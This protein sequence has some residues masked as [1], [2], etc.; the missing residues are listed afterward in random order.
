MFPA[1]FS[2]ITIADVKIKNRLVML[3][4]HMGYCSGGEVT[5]QLVEFYVERARGG[6][7]AIFVVCCYNDFGFSD[8][9][10]PGLD[11]DRFLPGLQRLTD[12]VHRYGTRI[13]AQ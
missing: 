8:P 13:I 4:M 10:L 7:G 1:L 2:P 3:P 9:T 6:V 11:D 5:D 12:A